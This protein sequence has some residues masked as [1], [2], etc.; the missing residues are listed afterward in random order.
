[1][2]VIFA[3]NE[4]SV[5]VDGEAVEG[6]RAIEYRRRQVRESIYAL[7]SAERIGMISG[8]QIVEGQLRVASTSPGLDRLDSARS[9]QISALLRHGEAQLS[10]TFDECY[11]MEKTFD[12]SVGEHGESVYA[13][14]ATR[15]REEPG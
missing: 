1:M 13:F 3:A 8:P 11:L 14:T 15:V 4:S 7:S 10:V 9:F 12:L 2:P 5:L 6:V